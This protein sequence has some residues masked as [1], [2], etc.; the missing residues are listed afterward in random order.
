MCELGKPTVIRW[1]VD[2]AVHGS[3]NRWAVWCNGDCIQTPQGKATPTLEEGRRLA[4]Q[5]E[6]LIAQGVDPADLL[7]PRTFEDGDPH[8]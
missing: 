5:R 8:R 2:P 1:E 3:H 6:D 7:I 4:S